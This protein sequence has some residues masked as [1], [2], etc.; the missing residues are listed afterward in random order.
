MG[1]VRKRRKRWV[2]DYYD[3]EGKRHWHTLPK[4]ATKDEANEKLGEIE[5]KIR[6]GVYTPTKELPYFPEVGD[7]YLTSKQTNVRHSTL[8]QYKGHF[9]NHLKPYFEKVKINQINFD[10]IEKFKHHSLSKGVTSPTLCKILITLGAILTYAVRMHYIDFN[11]AREVEKPKGNSLHG[12]KEEMVIL[13]PEEIRALLDATPTQKH[14]VLFMSAVLTGAREGELLGLKWDDFDWFNSQVHIRRTF[15]HGKFME[16]KTKTSRRKIDLA[17]ELV[18]ELKKWKLAS[19]K[20]E[21]DLVFP[22]ETGQTMNA[23]NM[24]VRNFFP[25]LRRAGLPQIRFHDL[26]HCYASLLIAQGEHPK[27]IQSQ[28][29]HSSINVTMDIYGHLMDSVNQRAASRLGRAVLG[30]EADQGENGSKMVAEAGK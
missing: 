29:G 3:R 15:N 9:E 26:R 6:Q 7:S 30:K 4:T 8:Q 27:Y 28:M 20:G 23:T 10:A 21:L 2:V 18:L 12:E 22:S 14:R 17:P 24:V 11:P 13:K 5:K 1:C 16:P 19:P 25:A